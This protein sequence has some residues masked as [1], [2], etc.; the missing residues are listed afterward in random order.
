MPFIWVEHLEISNR[1]AYKIMTDHDVL[2]TEV[3]SAVQ[4]VEGIE[5]VWDDHP[6]SGRRAILRVVIRKRWWLVVLY[7]DR[8]GR[9]DYWH[10]GSAYEINE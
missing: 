5:F 7:P 1:T 9:Q 4:G 3:R 6:E 10:L 8:W 2:P